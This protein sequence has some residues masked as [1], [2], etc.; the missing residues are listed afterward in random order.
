MDEPDDRAPDPVLDLEFGFTTWATSCR[1]ASPTL[2]E[3]RRP[4]QHEGPH[5]AGYGAA[6]RRWEDSAR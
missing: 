6:R 1:D 4:R 2:Q 5:A 3:C